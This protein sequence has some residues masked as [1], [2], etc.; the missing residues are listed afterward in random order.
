MLVLSR[1]IGETLIIGDG[2]EVRILDIT[3][4]QARIGIDAPKSVNIVR[5]ELLQ[6]DSMQQPQKTSASASDHSRQTLR[7]P[8]GR[9]KIL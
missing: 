9:R 6:R 4:N 1:R 3:G 8:F 2:I 7:L 5:S